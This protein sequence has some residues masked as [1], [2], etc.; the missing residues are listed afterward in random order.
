M[1]K[2]TTDEIRGLLDRVMIEEISFS[3]MVEVINKRISEANEPQ[4]KDGDFVVNERKDILIYKKKVGDFI[5]D[6]AY[7]TGTSMFVFSIDRP[8]TIQ[9][10]RH[11]TEAEKW[12]ILDALAKKGKRWNAEKKCIEDIPVRKFKKGDK[13]R[14]KDGISSKTHYIIDPSFVDDMDDLIG[15]TMIVDRYIDRNNCVK[16]KGIGWFFLEEWL[17]PYE[18]LK[19]GD[20]AIFWDDNKESAIIGKYDYFI[21]DFTFPHRDYRGV[22][23]KNAI[24]FESK[25]QYKKLLKGEI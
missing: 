2:F 19:K 25:E 9:I 22:A 6:H 23:W 17:E 1:K 24:K 18:E 5:Y 8:T 21:G 16:C 12:R 20:L 10:E 11:A 4:Y 14:I 7:Y 3:E 15:K 13:V